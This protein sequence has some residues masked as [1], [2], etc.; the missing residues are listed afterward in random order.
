MIRNSESE[1]AS[2]VRTLLKHQ[3]TLPDLAVALWF[4]PATVTSLMTDVLS[5]Y[6]TLVASRAPDAKSDTVFHILRLFQLIADHPDTRLPFVR[7][8]LPIYLFP[9]LQYSLANAELERF[10]A[11]IVVTIMSLVREGHRD[12][13]EYLVRADFIP[14]CL[15]ILSHGA[16]PVKVGAVFIFGRILAAPCGRKY[17]GDSP[18][19]VGMIVKILNVV[20]AELAK[21][22]DPE[23]SK[24]IVTVYQLLLSMPE[25]T[26][27][28]PE[29]VT[30]ELKTLQPAQ[31]CDDTYRMIWAQLKAAEG[32]AEKRQ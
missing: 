9:I 12:V 3:L 28:L 23:L 29:L 27:L 5:F 8:N 14:L 25:V 21:D 19:R 6:P 7:A 11:V 24:Y 1:R 31:E 4:S 20:F 30:D 10:V 18:D 17:V 22:F 13:L 16:R 15:R 2:A 32:R 26:Q